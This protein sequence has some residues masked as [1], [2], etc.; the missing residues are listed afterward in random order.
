MHF[1]D[2]YLNKTTMYQLVL[3]GLAVL[4]GIT[5]VLAFFQVLSFT[6]LDLLLSLIILLFTARVANGFC[7][8]F[9]KAA[10]TPESA[11]ITGFILFFILSP[12]QS[13]SDALVL[14]L[15]ATLA[16]VTKY[17]FVLHKKHI[18]NPAAAGVLL[19][20]LAGSGVA[21]WWVATPILFPVVLVLGLLIVRKI[22]RFDLFWSFIIAST[23]TYAVRSVI[24]GS[25]TAATMAQFFLSFPLIFF[26]T[27]MLTEPQTMPSNRTDRI[28]FGG[29]VGFLFSLA[30]S[31]GNLS[32]TPEFALVIGN[33]Y[34]FAVNQRR[35][36]ILTLSSI[37]QMSRGIFEYAFVS[38]APISHEAGQYMEWTSPHR[39]ADKRGTRRFFTIASAPG[40]THV[41]LG[42]RVPVESS[43]FNS[44][45]KSLK[46]GDQIQATGVTGAF[47]LPHD[48]NQ[49]LLFIAGGI[50]ITPF[51]SMFRYLKSRRERRDIVLIYSAIS[52]LDFAYQEEMDAYKDTIG[53]RI[54]YLPTDF[55]EV[56][57][58]DGPYGYITDKLVK[59]EIDDFKNR[60]WYLSGPSVMVDAYKKLAF[61][62]EVPTTHVKTD[63]FPGF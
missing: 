59:K 10:P 27:I 46:P 2:D 5:I 56:T 38:D 4:A 55:T 63:Y 1:I 16:M 14:M 26:G 7:A 51:M 11:Y 29:L 17:V 44:A 54:V 62:M 47:T 39:K 35:R 50:G 32:A 48:P 36:F 42:I 18:F 28:I 41:R 13:A 20:S 22:K 53:L 40:D 37:T 60:M 12:I 9:T 3:R 52:P 58:W 23:A 49:K 33:L 6:A 25:I 21:I 43:T 31:F 61:S 8:L 30:F 19:L 57:G 34:A 15:V 45:L 24:A